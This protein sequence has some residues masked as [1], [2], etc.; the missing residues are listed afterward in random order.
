MENWGLI[1]FRESYLLADPATAGLQEQLGVASII[2][3]EMAHMVSIHSFV[4]LTASFIPKMQCR[5]A[6][7]QDDASMACRVRGVVVTHHAVHACTV[8]IAAYH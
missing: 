6:L 5:V 3:H 1:T 4:P 7:A 2:A 8:K